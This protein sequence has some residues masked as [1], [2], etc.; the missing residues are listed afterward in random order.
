[1]LLA[2]GLG[3]LSLMNFPFGFAANAWPTACR[4]KS[5][6]FRGFSFTFKLIWVSHF[7]AHFLTKICKIC[8]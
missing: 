1:M 7:V 5:F 3:P 2:S 4:L 8:L 6:P